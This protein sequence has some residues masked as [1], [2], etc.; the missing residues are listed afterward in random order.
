MADIARKRFDSDIGIG[1]DGY[2]EPK[3]GSTS[4]KVFIVI[5]LKQ[6]DQNII[7]TYPWR[8][9]ALVRRSVMHTIFSLRNAL[10]KG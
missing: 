4:G 8:P 9:N 3:D 10:L 6:N 5:S 2:I 1:I 7:Q